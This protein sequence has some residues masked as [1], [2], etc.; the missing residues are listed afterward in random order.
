MVKNVSHIDPLTEWST[1]EAKERL[2]EVLAVAQRHPQIIRNRAKPVAVL[3]SYTEFQRMRA[4]ASK[5][6]LGDYFSEARAL[7]AESGDELVVPERRDR[8]LPELED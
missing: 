4:L 8:A 3:V 1:S 2:S 5:P 6:T 7:V